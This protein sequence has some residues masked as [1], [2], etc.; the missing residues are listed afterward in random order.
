MSDVKSSGGL[1]QFVTPKGREG[2]SKGPDGSSSI[3]DADSEGEAPKI[4]QEGSMPMNL[5]DSFVEESLHVSTLGLSGKYVTPK[6][7]AAKLKGSIEQTVSSEALQDASKLQN[8][9]PDA[10]VGE[11]QPGYLSVNNKE[12]KASIELKKAWPWERTALIDRAAQ[13]LGELTA[14][15][16]GSSASHL[17]EMEER[18]NA[19]ADAA[20]TKSFF[21]GLFLFGKRGK[22]R[23]EALMQFRN[24]YGLLKIAIATERKKMGIQV[25]DEAKEK[26]EQ[27]P[28]QKVRPAGSLKKTREQP[29]QSTEA[30]LTKFSLQLDQ[31]KE[32]WRGASSSIEYQKIHD[33]AVTF[34]KHLEALRT[35]IHSAGGADVFKDEAVSER[36]REVTSLIMDAQALIKMPVP[37]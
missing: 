28:S 9:R 7:S 25:S 14:T 8:V 24:A 35:V 19:I 26:N 5:D 13:G 32:N 2:V 10:Q 12:S 29:L 36:M 31:L 18:A 30:E 16:T 6:S 23:E 17:K 33:E 27:K 1:S 11:K 3:P 21:E 22:A 20:Q 4:L 37:R 34:L 15:V